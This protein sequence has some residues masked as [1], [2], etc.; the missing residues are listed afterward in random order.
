VTFSTQRSLYNIDWRQSDRL[1]PGTI[2]AIST[3]ENQF[4]SICKIVHVAQRPYYGGVGENPPRVDLQ[5]ANPV[6]DATF[7]PAEELV[8]IESRN[9]FFESARH[10]LVGL[11]HAAATE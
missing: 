1:T 7:D 2:L 4:K 3:K 6:E 11:Q 8:M 9:G 5:W 10:A